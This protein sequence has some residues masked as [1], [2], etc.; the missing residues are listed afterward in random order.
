VG[1]FIERLSPRDS[2]SSP[3]EGSVDLRALGRLSEPPS[4]DV[5][6]SVFHELGKVRD[7]RVAWVVRGRLQTGTVVCRGKEARSA[8]DGLRRWILALGGGG[9]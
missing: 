4:N 3:A 1:E 7:E 2:G 9:T 6:Q 8:F 5:A